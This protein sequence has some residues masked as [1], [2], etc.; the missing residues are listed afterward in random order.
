MADIFISHSSAD[1]DAAH[2]VASW[3]HRDRPGWSLFLTWSLPSTSPTGYTTLQGNG[4]S[5]SG[6]SVSRGDAIALARSTDW[7]ARLSRRRLQVWRAEEPAEP[8]LDSQFAQSA[9][10]DGADCLA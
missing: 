4:P 3:L 10:C 7:L 5:G 8:V 9:A 6:P 1:G 2:R